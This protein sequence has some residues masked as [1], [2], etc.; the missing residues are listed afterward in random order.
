MDPR[1]A[2]AV[3]V[4]GS[5]RRGSRREAWRLAA[6]CACGM[7]LM[8][9]SGYASGYA[10]MHAA[11][12]A[13]IDAPE[14][15]ASAYERTVQEIQKQIESGNLEQA[16]ELIVAAQGRFP[17]NGDLENLLGVVEIQKG[18]EAEAIR[19]FQAAIRD[20]PRLTGAYLNLSRI[21]MQEAAT[22]KAARAETLRLNQKV[23]EMDPGN[24]EA[25]YQMATSYLWNGDYRL[26]LEQVRKLSPEAREQVGAEAILCADRAALGPRETA[27]E[28]AKAL[29]A[30]ADLTEQDVDTCLPALRAARRADLIEMLLEASAGHKTLS[31]QGLRV[32]GLAKEANGKLKEAR[33]MLERAFAANSG[34]AAILE[35]LT[36][37]AKAADDYQGAL[38]Y[39]A[40]ARN[41]EPNNAELP[42]EFGAICVRM[43]LLAEARKAIAEALRLNPNNAQYNLGMGIVVSF[44]EDPSQS[45]PYLA[46]FQALEPK[47][48]QGPL[49]L[50][51]ANFRAKD[52][53]TAMTWFRR[54]VADEKTAADAHYYIGR[55]AHQQG[56]LDE[57]AAELKQAL[58]LRPGNADALAALGQVSLAKRDF[59]Q[60]DAY[61]QLALR[62]DVDNYAANFGLLQ[63][64]ARTG[65][66]RREGQSHRF[67]EVKKI[68]DERDQQ[69]M[70]AIEVRPDGAPV[71]PE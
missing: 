41:L 53:D 66:A 43:G 50:G 61:F 22:D 21:R 49:A 44:S 34:S 51:E 1:S 29:A 33:A 36:R 64:Y 3:T 59:G 25:R 42:Y 56:R 55:I 70:R 63:L 26:S 35:D 38:G 13:S 58:A 30:N 60:A 27:D 12:Y 7:L 23:L 16:R 14:Q 32:L 9:A 48:P 10:L 69:M 47:D 18:H 52:Y 40:H 8:H 54:A 39:L 17:H 15:E 5:R 28:A 2:M 37:V 4:T 65:D 62:A 46:K 67:D 11:G 71:R 20:N 45:L 57:A 24:D 6:Y 31:P 68:R 19:A